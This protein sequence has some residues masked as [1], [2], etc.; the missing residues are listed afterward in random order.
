MSARSELS[1][2]LVQARK[3]AKMT[4]RE[5]ADHMEWSSQKILRIENNAPISTTDLRQLLQLYGITNSSRVERMVKLASSNPK[6]AEQ[7]GRHQH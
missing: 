3:K 1:K 6:N 4:Q 2:Q 7:R 5:A